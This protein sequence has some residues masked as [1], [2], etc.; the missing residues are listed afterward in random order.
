VRLKK[1]EFFRQQLAK[2]TGQ[3]FKAIVLEVRN[4]GMFVE[5]PEVMAG[6]LIHVSALGDDFYT[7]DQAR[8]RFIGRKKKKV[9][10]AGDELEV[11][12]AR[13]DPFKQQLDFAPV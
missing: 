1:F 11:V 7:F 5:L 2:K 8:Q 9:Y 12:V 10:Q 4:F 3:T 6:G 13:V